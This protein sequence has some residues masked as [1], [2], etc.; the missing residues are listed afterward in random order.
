MTYDEHILTQQQGKPALRETYDD[1]TTD[2]PL[3][4][5]L[6]SSS[7]L[8][9]NPFSVMD[10]QI[11]RYQS[12]GI[13]VID[14]SKANP[15]L[16]TPAF[17]VKAGQE[18]LHLLENNRYSAF[19]GKPVLLQAAQQWYKSQHGVSVQWDTQLLATCGAGVALTAVTQC[20]L[21][22]GD[23]MLAVGPY[24]PPYQ[25]LADAAGARMVTIA[26]TAETDF[27]PDIDSVDEET[28]NAATL[29]LLNYPNNP[30]GALATRDLFR[31]LVDIAHRHH[32]IIA[33]DFAYAGLE[34]EGNRPI[35]LLATPGASDCAIEIVSMSKM[36]AMAGWRL[37]F[38]A[39]PAE[40]MR[41]IREYHHQL[42]SSPTGAVQDAGAVA[43]LSDQHSV[44]EL[45]LIYARRRKLFMQGLEA[46]GLSVFDSKGSVFVWVRVP[47]NQSSSQFAQE[48]LSHAHVAAMSGE[49]FGQYG[50]GYVRLSLLT[51][52]RRLQEAAARIGKI[53]K[54]SKL[55]KLGRISEIDRP[56]LNNETR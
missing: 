50:E 23:V 13:D 49:C 10:A 20:L 24:Y 35:S 25:A 16:P 34:S 37:G 45:S 31:R 7:N 8:P 15:D 19:D 32:V 46:A 18:A 14:L 42:C 28:W 17:I 44:H 48:L 6:G 12:Q 41:E 56:C 53:G 51:D 47:E 11:E 4:F 9:A 54:I 40:L 21:K 5:T 29:L 26:S 30:T 39:G 2:S 43:L 22:R 3:D 52:E 55:D 1:S 36:Y 33:N 38:C 27:L